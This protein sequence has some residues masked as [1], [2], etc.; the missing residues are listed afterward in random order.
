[1]PGLVDY[2]SSKWAAVGFDE[3]LRMELRRL[4]K[5]GVKTTCVNPFYI[6]TGMF[7]GVTTRFPFLLPILE[8][9]DVS[10]RIF[11]AIRRDSPVLCMPWLVYTIPLM[12]GLIPPWLMDFTAEVLGV[13]HSMDDFVGR[14]PAALGA[15]VLPAITGGSA[16][17]AAAGGG[18]GGG[19]GGSASGSGSGASTAST[20][21]AT[22]DGSK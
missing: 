15:P 16:S 13:S 21:A 22:E 4:G 18:G 9:D 5:T 10:Q 3:S 7:Q 2:A 20:A 17:S 14:G 1:M 11:T 6:N 12:R 19:A 8:P